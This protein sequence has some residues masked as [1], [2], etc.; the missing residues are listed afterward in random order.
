LVGQLPQTIIMVFPYTTLFRSVDHRGAQLSDS[1]AR[2]GTQKPP[3]G[4]APHAGA[5]LSRANPAGGKAAGATSGQ[6][7]L[8]AEMTGGRASR[9]EEHTSELQSPDQLVCRLLL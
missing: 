4:R 8:Y 1:D 3:R 7:G 9:S 5:E 2:N 6:A